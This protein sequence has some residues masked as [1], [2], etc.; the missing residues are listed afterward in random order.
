MKMKNNSNDLVKIVEQFSLIKEEFENRIQEIASQF[1]QAFTLSPEAIEG[2]RMLVKAIELWPE[3]QREYLQKA[4]SFG[5]Y[6]NWNTPASSSLEAADRGKKSLDLF[7]TAH[8]EHD[9]S[10]ITNDILNFCPKRSKV[11]EEA[12]IL[13]TE[14][15]YLASIP[16]LISQTDGICAEYLGAFLFSEHDRRTE[17]IDQNL[18]NNEDKALSIFL[19][20]LKDKNQFSKGIGKSS[21]EHKEMAPNR[22]GILH[23]SRNHL[24]YGTKINSL[25]CFSLLAFVVFTLVDEKNKTS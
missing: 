19:E 15:R 24:D 17:N 1:K 18:E 13:H 11:L 6:F 10:D 5:W 8:L 23:G 20:L 22:S 25:K 4:S 21:A 14:G 3:W 7:M 9:W 12:F 2:I 16:L